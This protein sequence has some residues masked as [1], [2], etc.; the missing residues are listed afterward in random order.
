MFVKFAAFLISE[1]YI[2]D[3]SKFFSQVLLFES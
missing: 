1:I 2:A 3:F